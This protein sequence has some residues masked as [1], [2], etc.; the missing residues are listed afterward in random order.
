[1]LSDPGSTKE[2]PD[3]DEDEE[4]EERAESRLRWAWEAEVASE[5]LTEGVHWKEKG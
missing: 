4:S 2:S 1:M 5:G 3:E